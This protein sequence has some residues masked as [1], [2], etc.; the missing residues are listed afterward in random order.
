MHFF[1]ILQLWLAPFF[2][3]SSLSDLKYNLHKYR[4]KSDFFGK[5]R[6]F[7]G[8][9]GFFREKSD[10]FGKISD[11]FRKIGD[12]CR[13]FSDFFTE[14]FSTRK[15]FPPPPKTDFSPKNRPK[16]SIFLSLALTKG[17]GLFEPK[18]VLESKGFEYFSV[19]ILI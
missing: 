15:S 13:F 3:I 11:F 17:K 16:K 19:I 6:I 9:I 10:F 4:E 2:N 12:F 5:N 7:S 14:D 8:K 18:C 1:L